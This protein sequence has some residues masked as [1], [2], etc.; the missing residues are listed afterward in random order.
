MFRFVL[1]NNN[2]T[3]MGLMSEWQEQL[4][5]IFFVSPMVAMVMFYYPV[6]RSGLK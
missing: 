3:D 6:Q 5:G 4:S 1:I 2:V